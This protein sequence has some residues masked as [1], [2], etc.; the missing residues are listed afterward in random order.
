MGVFLES[1]YIYNKKMLCIEKNLK[2]SN[3]IIISIVFPFSSTTGY[4]ES[5]PFYELHDKIDTWNVGKRLHNI[6][7][8]LHRHIHIYIRYSLPYSG[9][10]KPGENP[11]VWGLYA[12]IELSICFEHFGNNVVVVAW[13]R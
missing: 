12:C 6:S 2:L 1:I 3:T 8:H 11:L 9:G 7:L 13:K 10:E 5:L 4:A